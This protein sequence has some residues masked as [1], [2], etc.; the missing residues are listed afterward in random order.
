MPPLFISRLWAPAV[1]CIDATGLFCKTWDY[2]KFG[3]LNR[4]MPG[5]MDSVLEANVLGILPKPWRNG[6]TAVNHLQMLR[7][8]P[9][10]TIDH[11]CSLRLIPNLRA[12]P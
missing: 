12:D 11:I 6:A 1:K 7:A 5:W 3:H 9:L 2:E 10:H 8:H 4:G